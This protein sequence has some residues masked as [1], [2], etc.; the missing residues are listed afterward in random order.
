MVA[1]VTAGIRGVA[2]SVRGWAAIGPLLQ[3][4]WAEVRANKWLFLIAAL[5]VIAGRVMATDGLAAFELKYPSAEHGKATASLVVCGICI[6]A[7]LLALTNL[8]I[9][10]ADRVFPAL[11]LPL[12]P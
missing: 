10:A 7:A 5:M 9:V 1:Q 3:L 2:A 6:V 4:M 12:I 8:T 11:K